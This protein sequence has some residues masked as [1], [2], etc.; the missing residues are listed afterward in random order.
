LN[1]QV[2]TLKH[3]CA[4]GTVFAEYFPRVTF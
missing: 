3:F 2:T 1:G 4:L